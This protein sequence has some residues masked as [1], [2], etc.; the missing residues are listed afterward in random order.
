MTEGDKNNVLSAE[1][2]SF[3]LREHS[4]LY[5]D[6]K[7]FPHIVLD[8]FI[9][10]DSSRMLAADFPQPDFK[11]LRRNTNTT[12]F[13]GGPAAQKNKIGLNDEALLAPSI[14]RFIWE[15]NSGPF[16]RFLEEITG[17]PNL[18]P[19]PSLRGAGTHQVLSG[20]L[21]RVH[22]DFNKHPL[23][24]LDRR[25]NVLIYFNENWQEEWGGALELWNKEVTAAQAVIS[26][27]M[28]R[29]VI[30]NTTSTSYHGHPQPLLCP[31]GT[32][33]KSIAMYYYTNGRPDD[34]ACEAHKTLWPKMPWE[35]IS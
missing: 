16:I 4:S 18:L 1:T 27:L 25:I 3:F 21:L 24:H 22:A 31:Q 12:V 11:Q 30:F 7:P 23:Y 8:D 33:R 6:A 29:C 19:D 34:E 15:L 28:G 5:N 9:D 20:G 2:L 32:A 13:E 26:P 10:I 35:K 17:I 14:R